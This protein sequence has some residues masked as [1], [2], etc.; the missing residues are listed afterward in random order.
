MTLIFYKKEANLSSVHGKLK[1][2]STKSL[3]FEYLWADKIES[4]LVIESSWSRRVKT[5]VLC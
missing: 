5:T 2:S 3:A 1:L 4:Y